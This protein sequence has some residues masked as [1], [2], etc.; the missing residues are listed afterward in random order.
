MHNICTHFPDDE[1]SEEW[2]GIERLIAA[3]YSPEEGPEPVA[4]AVGLFFA[5][6]KGNQ[7]VI[8]ALLDGAATVIAILGALAENNPDVLRP[9]AR[10]RLVWPDLVGPK[11]GNFDKNRWLL[12][13]LEV[14]KECSMRGT[15]NPQAPATQTALLMLTWLRLNQD[16][17][18]LTSL[19]QGTREQ[20]F[21][22]GW[23]ALLDVTAHH[24]E[25]DAYLRQIGQHYGQHSKDWSAKKRHGSN[26]RKQYASRNQSSFGRASRILR[27]TCKSPRTKFPP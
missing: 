18:E 24:P 25:K 16:A 12:R 3:L 9:I 4:D 20:W 26:T 17:L 11:E 14:G 22:A 5:A 27:R 21:E 15:W 2:L 7:V 19:T 1:Y 23:T 6:V 13:H 8:K 10:R